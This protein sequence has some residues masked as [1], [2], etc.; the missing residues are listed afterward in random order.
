M[1]LKILEAERLAICE[2]CEFY[3]SKSKCCSVVAKP[4][5]P[6]L[7]G[8]IYHEN[9]IRNPATRCPKNK[10]GFLPSRH[11]AMTNDFIIIPTHMML[12]V[13]RTG[14]TDANVLDLMAALFLFSRRQSGK[15]DLK[16][17][18]I[19]KVLKDIQ[20]LPNDHKYL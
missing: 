2:V 7:R 13:T 16:R 3:N 6:V 12:S 11:A 19:L 9:G 20:K 14:I 17:S 8:Y 1:N 18:D 4:G 10:W 5:H 15:S